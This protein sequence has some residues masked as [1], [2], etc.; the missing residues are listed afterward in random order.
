[1]K[2]LE[3]DERAAKTQLRVDP[4]DPPL[5]TKPCLCVPCYIAALEYMV[6]EL[7][8]YAKELQYMADTEKKAQRKGVKR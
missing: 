2:C 8:Q 7:I 4:R 3:C 5:D 1:M 6:E